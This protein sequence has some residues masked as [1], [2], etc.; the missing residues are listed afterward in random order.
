[1][2]VEDPIPPDSAD[3]FRDLVHRTSVPIATGERYI[4]IQEF[5]LLLAGK[6]AQYVRPDVCALG[7]ITAAKKAAAIAEAHYVGVVPHNPLGP[8]STAACL[9]LDACIPNFTIQEYPSFYE[10][11]NEGE[12]MVDPF[13]VEEGCLIIPEAPGIGIE[14]VPDVDEKFPPTNGRHAFRT[15]T[16]FDGSVRDF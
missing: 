12:M 1:M 8:V 4:S 6:G 16:S 15:H 2:F 11:G 14:L 5:E 13:Q 10:S 7:G 9:Q 3:A